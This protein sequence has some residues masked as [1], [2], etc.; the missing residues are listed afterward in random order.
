[1]LIGFDFAF[2]YPKG[3]AGCLV[4][5]ATALDLWKWLATEIRDCSNNDN[6]RFEVASKMNEIINENGA[7]PFWGKPNNPKKDPKKEYPSIP[8]R[9][10]ECAGHQPPE[11]RITEEKAKGAK[12]VWQLSGAGVVGSQV[13]LGL[14]HLSRLIADSDFKEHTVV[15]P[16]ETGL[17][18]PKHEKKVVIVEIYPSLLRE[19]IEKNRNEDEIRDRAQMRVTAEAFAGLDA[20]GGLAPL[21]NGAEGLTD[22]QR[23]VIETEEGWILGLGHEESLREILR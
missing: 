2:G 8:S 23:K 7:G 6:N 16:F 4:K 11:F 18:L 14:P 9:K 10:T 15:W 1:M 20:R 13:L 17:R 19:E 21:F 5:N 22:C 12:S 3:V